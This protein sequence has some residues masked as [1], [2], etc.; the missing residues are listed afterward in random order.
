MTTDQLENVVNWLQIRRYGLSMGKYQAASVPLSG[1]PGRAA[2]AIDPTRH[3]SILFTTLSDEFAGDPTMKVAIPTQEEWVD[4]VVDWFARHPNHDLIIRAHP[5]LAG[6]TGVGRANQ[7]INWFESLKKRIPSNVRIILP[8]SLLSSYD[9]MDNGNLALTYAST[10]GLEMMALGKPVA[11]VPGIALYEDVPGVVHMECAKTLDA[12]LDYAITLTPSTEY[13]RYSFR[14]IYR[15]FYHLLLPFT[16]VKVTTLRESE[17]RYTSD[18]ALK[19]GEDESLDRICAF[20]LYG[21]PIHDAPN[22]AQISSQAKEDAFF[23]SLGE[24]DTW[25]NNSQVRLKARGYETLRSGQR[26]LRKMRR[27]PNL[28]KQLIEFIRTPELI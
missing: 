12:T 16:L 9:L 26:T 4:A 25:L 7:Q 6:K 17:L 10:A 11:V 20:L 21:A 19:P 2:T 1:E 14:L 8:D 22:P 18:E 13:Q 3:T 24:V 23:A 28:A 27:V 15:F 5:S